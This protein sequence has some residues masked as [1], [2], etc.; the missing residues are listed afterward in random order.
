MSKE[1]RGSAAS[2]GYNARWR[3]AR[4]TFLGD[5]PLCAYCLKAG[6]P[7]PATLVDH[8]VPHKGD[9]A[10]FWDT[11]NWQSLCAPCHNSLKQAEEHGNE[12]LTPGSDAKGLPLD[13]RHPWNQ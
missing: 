6:R 5:N 2:R 4:I 13:A 11:S 10:L 9:M 3:K 12:K 7:K 8:I 1:W